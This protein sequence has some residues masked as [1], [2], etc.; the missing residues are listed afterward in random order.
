MLDKFD[1]MFHG[2]GFRTSN[3]SYRC[4]KASFRTLVGRRK[5]PAVYGRNGVSAAAPRCGAEIGVGAQHPHEP[6]D[7]KRRIVEHVDQHRH[8]VGIVERARSPRKQRR[9]TTRRMADTRWP[10]AT[11]IRERAPA[12]PARLAPARAASRSSPAARAAQRERH[13]HRGLDQRRDDNAVDHESAASTPC[14]VCNDAPQT[15]RARQA[16]RRRHD[17]DRPGKKDV[18]SMA[19]IR[20][21]RMRR[22]DPSRSAQRKFAQFRE[23][24]RNETFAYSSPQFIRG[25][26]DQ[27]QRGPRSLRVLLIR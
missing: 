22:R 24:R 10:P 21:R 12:P 20:A 27:S 16:M 14:G 25:L 4:G 5:A 13:H 2:G 1:Q 3:K 23:A 7:E 8:E 18:A 19:R 6:D 9:R 15:P 17:G 26:L 11:P